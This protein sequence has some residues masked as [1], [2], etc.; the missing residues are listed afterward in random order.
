[1]ESLGTCQH[2][3]CEA[4]PSSIYLSSFSLSSYHRSATQTLLHT[5]RF[6]IVG[7]RR[8]V[9]ASDNG[10]SALGMRRELLLLREVRHRSINIIRPGTIIADPQT[11]CAVIP[12][13]IR[14]RD[15][16][17]ASRFAHCA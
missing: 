10:T 2:E 5:S 4:L 1:M 16:H 9:P 11:Y 13:H 3:C 12:V 15:R 6:L 17:F 8:I 14:V 7:K